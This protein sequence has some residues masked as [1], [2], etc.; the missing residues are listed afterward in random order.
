MA[1]TLDERLDLATHIPTEVD[2]L[3][4]PQ[5]QSV[6]KRNNYLEQVFSAEGN[7]LQR[8]LVQ[9]RIL[10]N[11]N[12]RTMAEHAGLSPHGYKDF[13]HRGPNREHAQGH[14]VTQTLDAWRKLHVSEGVREQC[15]DLLMPETDI[16]NLYQRMGYDLGHAHVSQ[17][18]PRIFNTLWQRRKALR[19]S[20]PDYQELR[21]HIQLLYPVPGGKKTQKVENAEE[22]RKRRLLAARTVWE[23]EKENQLDE[24]TLE[25]PLRT[26]LI[27]L[28]R[29][30]AEVY[31]RNL[32][33]ETLMGTWR[34]SPKYAAAITRGDVVPW[35]A[36]QRIATKLFT[37]EQLAELQQEWEAMVGIDAQRSTFAKHVRAA[38]EEKGE[39]L[40]DVGRLLHIVPPEQRGKP[41]KVQ[42][43]QRRNRYRPDALLRGV[44]DE[45]GVSTKVPVESL[46]A[47]VATDGHH[48]RH[49]RSSY[50]ET[51]RRTLER[52][53]SWLREDGL[54][55]R[56]VRERAGIDTM[57]LARR[58]WP[59]DDKADLRKKS[60]LLQRVERQEGQNLLS[61]AELQRAWDMLE[62]ICSE[63]RDQVRIW[64]EE[65]SKPDPALLV[66]TSVKDMAEKITQLFDGSSK[67][68]SEAMRNVDERR[69]RWLRPDLIVDTRKGAFVPPLP[70]LENLAQTR[71]VSVLPQEIEDDWHAAYP[72]YLR[73]RKDRPV[74]H[75]LGRIIGTA[76]AKIE[77]H[78]AHFFQ[79]NYAG[80]A[81]TL[82]SAQFYNL[83]RHGDVPRTA[84]IE[85]MLLSAG[86]ER[87]SPTW[88]IATM[89]A[90]RTSVRSAIAQVMEMH[91]LRGHDVSPVHLV[92]LC[93]DE[94]KKALEQQ[95]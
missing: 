82:A 86:I 48:A 71:G 25:P 23:Y 17:R 68:V 29:K 22:R 75:P 4:G 64:K 56:L 72:L 81:P 18:I 30:S 3:I 79:H 87:E 46:I 85:R 27:A 31:G 8:L 2:D 59:E 39:T 21:E 51:R 83:Q 58:L 94:C 12:M 14:V 73:K 19:P 9:V 26:F 60:V 77:P 36:V 47:A 67:T 7:D 37:G 91:Q 69:F 34:M 15:L 65:A 93:E 44:L 11:M 84:V 32:T 92:G 53:G 95:A 1:H 61:S 50:A 80:A 10:L 62:T 66:W 38:L 5:R 63:R 70:T 52:S 57:T 89:V 54:E 24:R 41:R 74:R 78:A 55:M 49:L 42:P 88:D 45:Q 16:W 76:I 43:V 13:E 90:S 6:T 28:E 33:L 35:E 40:A 20:V